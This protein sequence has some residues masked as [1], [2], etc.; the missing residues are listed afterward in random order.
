MF[1]M[2]RLFLA[3]AGS[4]LLAACSLDELQQENNTSFVNVNKISFTVEPLKSEE[5]VF[6]RTNLTYS[7][8]QLNFAWASG[9]V[10]GLFPI[11]PVAGSQVSQ[12]LDFETNEDGG[13]SADF[14]GGAWRLRKDNTYCAYYPFCGEMKLNETY[15][16]IPVDMTGQTQKSNNSTAHLGAYDYMYSLPTKVD[17]ELNVSLHYKHL[18]GFLV[19][20]LIMP[21]NATMTELSLVAQEPIFVTK[22]KMNAKE[23]TFVATETSTL[24]SLNLDNMKAVAGQTLR[25]FVAALPTTNESSVSVTANIVS[26]YGLVYTSPLNSGLRVKSGYKYNRNATLARVTDEYD[27]RDYVDLGTGDGTLWGRNNVDV[28]DGDVPE[29][30]GWFDYE[31]KSNYSWSTYDTFI[32]SKNMCEYCSP[33]DKGGDG[34]YVLDPEYDDVAYMKVTPLHHWYIPTS[35][36][37]QN[38]IEKCKWDWTSVNGVSGYRI[39]NKTNPARWIFLPANG[40]MAGTTKTDTSAGYYWASDLDR[41]SANWLKAYCLKIM[42][43]SYTLTSVDRCYGASVRPIYVP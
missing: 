21:E 23:G 38:L 7:G 18:C 36:Q 9:D 40:L 30:Y 33:A 34:Q 42:D 14:D 6:T 26:S 24:I 25:L 10:V 8:S 4:A 27:D 29:Y 41:N 32:S 28:V 43:G 37:W 31:V 19:L 12:V 13:L 15:A 20:D 35:T 39:S 1:P 2:K 11:A 16:D 5:S 17:D 22:A 3:I